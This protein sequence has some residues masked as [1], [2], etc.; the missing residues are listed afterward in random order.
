[1]GTS[2]KFSARFRADTTIS[3]IVISATDVAVMQAKIAIANTF[4]M[5]NFVIISPPRFQTVFRV[6]FNT[7]QQIVLA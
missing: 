5:F 3:S 4:F 6:T 7:G 1:M 2:C